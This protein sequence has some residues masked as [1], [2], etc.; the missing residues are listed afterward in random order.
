VVVAVIASREEAMAKHAMEWALRNVAR[1]GDHIRLLALLRQGGAPGGAGRRR[2]W[3]LPWL[4][5]DCGGAGKRE[6]AM[7][8]LAM[9]EE[10]RRLCDS[11]RVRQEALQRSRCCCFP[12]P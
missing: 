8:E 4:A 10:L 9:A 3:S 1:A 6:A 2:L 11:K 12:S 5:G 7:A